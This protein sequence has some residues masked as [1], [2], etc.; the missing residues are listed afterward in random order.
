[1]P[2]NNKSWHSKED[3]A[4]QIQMC[5]VCLRK[6]CVDCIGRRLAGR[7]V[8]HKKVR[9]PDINP[10]VNATD[11]KVLKLYLSAACDREIAELANMPL[12]TVTHV[13][14]K[15]ELPPIRAVSFEDRKELVDR[16]L[17]KEA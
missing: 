10:Y 15:F 2:S 16:W 3:S 5:L 8:K 6:D 1:M 7:K 17:R 4:E 9:I 11:V 12:S 13:R 14:Q